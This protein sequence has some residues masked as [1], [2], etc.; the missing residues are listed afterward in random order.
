MNIPD[1]FGHDPQR[2][3]WGIGDMGYTAYQRGEPINS[4]PMRFGSRAYHAWRGGWRRAAA[5]DIARKEA[6]DD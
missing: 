5:E 2:S 3:G 4:C 6:E 1:N